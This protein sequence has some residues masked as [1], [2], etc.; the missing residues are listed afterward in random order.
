[1]RLQPGVFLVSEPL[2]TVLCGERQKVLVLRM[3]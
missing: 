3:L 1:M 2:S